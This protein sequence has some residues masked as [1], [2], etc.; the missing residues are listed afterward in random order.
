MKSIDGR[1]RSCEQERKPAVGV[2]QGGNDA[3]V[4]GTVTTW[5]EFEILPGKRY[6]AYRWGGW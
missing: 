6:K 1:S 5:K 3:V 2:E 4:T